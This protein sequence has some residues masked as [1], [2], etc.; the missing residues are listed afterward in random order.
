[1]VQ[2]AFSNN[3]VPKPVTAIM[4][5]VVVHERK[6]SFTEKSKYSLTIQKPAS[7][8]LSPKILPAPIAK[9]TK[10]GSALV[11]TI[12]GPIKLAEVIAATV[13]DP[14]QTCIKAAINHPAMIGEKW[15]P[16]NKPEI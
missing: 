6:V 13:E 9:T 5:V 3:I 11:W 7:V 14:K 10:I 16:S 15:I 4:I 8:T 2:I 12:S 1:M